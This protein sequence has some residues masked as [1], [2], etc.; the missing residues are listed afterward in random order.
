MLPDLS[1]ME[2]EAIALD[3][4]GDASYTMNREPII[5]AT[6]TIIQLEISPL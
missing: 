6:I 1:K 2:V 3:N 5:L 4:S